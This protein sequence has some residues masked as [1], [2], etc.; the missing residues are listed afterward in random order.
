MN[1]TVPVAAVGTAQVNHVGVQNV[2][3][4]L[5]PRHRFRHQLAGGFG[6]VQALSLI[7]I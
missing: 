2:A 7:H 4:L 5:V 1:K 3:V 6:I